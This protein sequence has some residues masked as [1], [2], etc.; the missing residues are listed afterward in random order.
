MLN[1]SKRH[2]SLF[3]T[4]IGNK[5]QIHLYL[6]SYK[7]KNSDQYIIIANTFHSTTHCLTLSCYFLLTEILNPVLRILLPVFPRFMKVLYIIQPNSERVWLWGVQ[8]K[9]RWWLQ[10]LGMTSMTLRCWKW[11]DFSILF[12]VTPLHRWV[13]IQS[14]GIL[15]DWVLR[16]GF[17]PVYDWVFPYTTYHNLLWHRLWH[18]H[19]HFWHVH[20]LK[21]FHACLLKSHWSKVVQFHCRI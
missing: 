6:L 20:P 15:S 18:L 8:L 13:N 7:S 9:M 4:V 5:N 12:L 14:H 2:T 10:I 1:I 11:N 3:Q 16:V 19:D 21:T 17:R